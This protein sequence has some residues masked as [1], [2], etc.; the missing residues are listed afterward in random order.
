MLDT[1]DS[2]SKICNE[3]LLPTLVRMKQ[4]HDESKIVCKA[5]ECDVLCDTH[6]DKISSMHDGPNE[7]RVP[8]LEPEEQEDVATNEYDELLDEHEDTHSHEDRE[9]VIPYE[10]HELPLIGQQM[11]TSNTACQDM[12]SA[13]RVVDLVLFVGDRGY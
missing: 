9:E 6:L 4:T 13:S 7:V 1:L 11:E 2:M 5:K 8:D 12:E 10:L 3:E